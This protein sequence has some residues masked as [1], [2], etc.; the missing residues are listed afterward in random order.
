MH[1]TSTLYQRLL[2]DPHHRKEMR[3]RIAG[4]DYRQDRIVSLE[5]SGGVFDQP[6]IGNCASRQIDLTLR[7]PDCAT[8]ISNGRAQFNSARGLDAPVA[9]SWEIPR[10]AEIRV[11]VRLALGDEVSEWIPKGVFYI[12]TRR[13]DT[14]TGFLELHGFDAMRR[15]GEVWD[16]DPHANWPM[17]GQEAV[18][19]IAA[20]MGVELD[21]RTALSGG[22]PVGY[23]VDED[24]DL[25]MADVL[26][27]I[28]VSEAGNW[29]IS[30]EGKLLLLKLGDI[31]PETNYLVDEN[32]DAI[33][34]G[35]V[36]ILAG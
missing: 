22:F 6:D 27:G 20:Q 33:T 12:S 25:A 31:P 26:E 9:E 24:G 16:I 32:G 10:S 14:R 29:V 18:A 30:D 36:R 35:G 15:A 1:T 2:R 17:S 23:P 7:D 19:D 3:V 5:T 8:A 28:A 21:P 34:F 13:L 4:T 11:F